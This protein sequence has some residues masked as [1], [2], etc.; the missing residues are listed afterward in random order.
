MIAMGEPDA[1]VAG[2]TAAPKASGSRLSA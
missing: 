1:T 2:D